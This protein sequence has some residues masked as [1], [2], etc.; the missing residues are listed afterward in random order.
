MTLP[1]KAA[2]IVCTLCAAL[3]LTVSAHP[4]RTDENGGHKRKYM[5]NRQKRD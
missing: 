2:L 5:A 3:T 1:K 4:G